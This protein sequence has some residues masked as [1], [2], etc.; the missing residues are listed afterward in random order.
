MAIMKKSRIDLRHFPGFFPLTALCLF[1]LYAP[2]IIVMLYSFNDS[3][4]ITR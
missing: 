4:S 3:P 2:L 1:L